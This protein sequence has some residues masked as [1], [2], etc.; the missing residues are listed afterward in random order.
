MDWGSGN[1]G[2][3][4]SFYIARS[5]FLFSVSLTSFLAFFLVC[6]KRVFYSLFNFSY[7]SG[8]AFDEI[9]NE[10]EE[11]IEEGDNGP[12]SM[13]IKYMQHAADIVKDVCGYLHPETAE[14]YSLVALMFEELNNFS[15]AA[16][17][18]RHSFLISERVFSAN[19]VNTDS[20]FHLLQHIEAEV[21]NDSRV[22]VLCRIWFE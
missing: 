8:Y 22:C 14:V 17:W 5:S 20:I 21:M 4:I 19:H 11:N 12:E 13:R 2:K 3:W 6:L 10:E 16:E 9:E 18:I 1:V 7:C 15:A